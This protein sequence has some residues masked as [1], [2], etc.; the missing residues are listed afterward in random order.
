MHDVGGTLGQVGGTFD[1]VRGKGKD[2]RKLDVEAWGQVPI[3]KDRATCT[4]RI[5]SPRLHGA[6][7]DDTAIS[8]SGRRLLADLLAQLTPAQMES[9]FDR[10]ARVRLRGRQAGQHGRVPMGGRAAG[11]DP[12]DHGGGP[13]SDPVRSV[14]RSRR[15]RVMRAIQ[16]SHRAVRVA[17]AIVVVLGG[18]GALAAVV[19]A[20]E[21]QD[22]L[23]G[24]AATPTHTSEMASLRE[25]L[26]ALPVAGL[27]G[28]A[29]AFR[30]Q[31]RGTP[32]RQPAVIQTQIILALVGALVMLVVGASLARAFGIVG[33][34][35]LV[36]YRAKVDDPKD[37][38]IMLSCLGLGLAS[39]VGIYWI[40]A[41]ATLFILAASSGCWSRWSRSSRK[42]FLLKIG[43]KDSPE[44]RTGMEAILRDS[45][46]SHELR[47]FV[48]GRPHLR[49]EAAPDRRR[50]IALTQ[51]LVALG[52]GGRTR[53]PWNG[54][55]R[56]RRTRPEPCNSWCS[57]TTARADPARRSRG[58]RQLDRHA[59]LPARP[60]G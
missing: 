15:R 46:I 54:R 58:A 16:R 18:L 48:A 25:A 30:P 59:H 14:R 3:W 23:P 38:G 42:E 34:A 8:E 32:P 40:A 31:R 56:N 55:T 43:A 6:S 17:L 52:N 1:R 22:V 44:L 9:L 45:K 12:P 27:L 26:I 21:A 35:S 19:A 20:P 49:G 57:R 7:F 13:M 11:Q 51:Q 2:E 37:A 36:R 10:G 60:Q 53:W 47:G 5:K 4:V 28:A 29:L 50:R 41:F 39:G 24:T 33:A